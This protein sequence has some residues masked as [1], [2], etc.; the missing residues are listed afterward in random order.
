[1]RA[2]LHA[3]VSVYVNCSCFLYLQ[4]SV[5]KCSVLRFVDDWKKTVFYLVVALPCFVPGI[6]GWIAV[7]CGKLHGAVLQS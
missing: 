5:A 3:C 4:H 7:F 1:M 2:C 6:V